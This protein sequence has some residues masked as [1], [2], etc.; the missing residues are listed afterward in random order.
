MT[1]ATLALGFRDM[2]HTLAGQE[3]FEIPEPPNSS[4]KNLGLQSSIATFLPLSVLTGV[5]TVK[6]DPN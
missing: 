2:D 4:K 3:W 6:H 1:R 5:L